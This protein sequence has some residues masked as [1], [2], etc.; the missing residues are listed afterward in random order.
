MEPLWKIIPKNLGYW[1]RNFKKN[2]EN[3][4]VV[5]TYVECAKRTFVVMTLLTKTCISVGHRYSN[6]TCCILAVFAESS[7]INSKHCRHFLILYQSV[8]WLI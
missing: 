3:G 1:K 6:S 7:E 8:H 2:K 5:P 4:S